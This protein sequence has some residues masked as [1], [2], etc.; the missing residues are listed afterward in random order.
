MPCAPVV[1]FAYNRPEH[2]KRTIDALRKNILA[3]ETPL[4]IYCDGPKSLNDTSKVQSVRSYVKTIEGFFDIHIIYRDKNY[5]LAKSIIA[6][7][8]E[9]LQQFEKVIV[10]EDDLIT[11]PFFLQFLNDSLN[12]YNDDER[13]ITIH[14]FLCAINKK[15]PETFFLCD[16]GCL[17]WAT[18]RR[19]WKLYD[20]DSQKLLN[21]IISRDLQSEFDFN[22]AYPYTK[23]LK[24]QILGKISSWAIP[25]YAV[26]FLNKKLTLYPGKTLVEHIGYDNSG[27]HCGNSG[28]IQD[29][30]YE[31]KINVEVIPVKENAEIKKYISKFLW[32]SRFPKLQKL[33]K[34]LHL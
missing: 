21:E 1:V 5:G 15:T 2:L 34:R 3:N 24:N 19:A 4:Y 27:T 9:I 25:W 23:M 16:P 18:W 33:I 22:N 26:A 8:T 6:G 14:G 31:Q 11:S 29:H 32:W 28:L 30:P 17:G 12:M 13:I 20:H 10:L 7:V